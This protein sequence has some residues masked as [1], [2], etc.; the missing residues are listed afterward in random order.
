[1]VKRL[2]LVVL[3]LIL[4][5]T[6]FAFARHRYVERHSATLTNP[7]NA[8]ENT[9]LNDPFMQRD[10]FGDWIKDEWVLAIAVPAAL[11]AAGA[12]LALKR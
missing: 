12:A 2:I 11:V 5:A 9:R 7:F 10:L 3:G 4:A 6:S 8:R 1:M